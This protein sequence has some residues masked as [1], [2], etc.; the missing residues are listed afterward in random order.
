M[1]SVASPFNIHTSSLLYPIRLAQRFGT[2]AP[3]ALTALGNPDI[4]SLPKTALFCSAHC[5]GKAI[6]PIYDQVAKWRDEG[7]CVISGFHSPVEKECLGILLRGSQPIIICPARAIPKRIP[8][9]W[10]KPLEENRLL[11]LSFFGET[12]TRITAEL[13]KRRNEL[14]AALANSVFIAHAEPGG[15]IETLLQKNGQP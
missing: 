8:Q 1:T 12:E 9:E 14:V 10:E 13:A 4:L 6:L 11:I 5:P 15:R 3:S 7:Q 2:N